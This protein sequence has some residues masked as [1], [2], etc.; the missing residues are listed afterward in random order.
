MVSI[1]LPIRMML[2]KFIIGM[3][4]LGVSACGGDN[5]ST[6]SPQQWQD[7]TV[8]IETQPAPVR[9]GMNEFLVII[10]N[11]GFIPKKDFVVSLRFSTADPWRQA[12][13][14]GNIGVFHKAMMV[15]PSHTT[16]FVNI[17]RKGV[18]TTLLFPM[19]D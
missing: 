6:F 15:A 3:F 7:L 16:L 10:S 1:E 2:K 11:K 19:R 17:R 18:E 13:Q 9:P 14:D 8:T 5:R 4:L 12:I